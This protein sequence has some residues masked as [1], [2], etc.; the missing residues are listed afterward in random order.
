VPILALHP[1]L[2]GSL[3]ELLAL[4]PYLEGSLEE[5][6]RAVQLDLPLQEPCHGALERL[7]AEALGELLDEAG[8]L[9]FRSKA[10]QFKKGLN[11]EAA[12]QVLYEGIMRALGYAKNKTPSEKLARRL[13]LRVLREFALSQPLQDRV[14]ALQALLMG[15]AGLLPK[16]RYKKAGDNGDM[17][18]RELE[19]RWKSF[20]F[21]RVMNQREWRFFRVRPENFP[22]RRLAA[23]SYLLVRYGEEGLLQSLLGPVSQ[24]FSRQGYRRLEQ[25]FIVT[26]SGYWATHFDFGVESYCKHSLIGHGR[27]GEIVVNILIPF[28]FAWAEVTS[29]PRLKGQALEIYRSY[30]RLGE[31]WVTRYMENQIYG[32]YRPSLMN[33]ACRQQGLI[34][35][36]KS[37]CAE[38]LCDQ[39]ALGVTQS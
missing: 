12:D 27:A 17:W 39:C 25:E 16:Q 36:F 18:T 19:R 2:E 23:V 35:F 11:A 5:L 38:R 22:T 15:M 14:L 20:R 4:H 3:E 30:P 31:N 28:C 10:E 24:A 13:P 37:F 9:R 8:E 6:H 1:Y 34:H 33:S 7:G 26:T 32:E 21:G 29:R